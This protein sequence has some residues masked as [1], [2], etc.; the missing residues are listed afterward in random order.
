MMK[1][2]GTDFGSRPTTLGGAGA[3]A[4]AASAADLGVPCYPANSAA[5]RAVQARQKTWRSG[6]IH[7]VLRVEVTMAY[8]LLAADLNGKSDPYA[9]VTCNGMARKTR[10]IR[11]TLAPTWEETFEMRGALDDFLASPVRLQV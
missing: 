9:V 1:K 6:P 3:L 10:V 5:R 2:S 8:G 11:Y 4:R 7:G